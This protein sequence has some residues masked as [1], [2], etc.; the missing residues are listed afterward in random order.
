MAPSVLAVLAVSLLEVLEATKRDPSTD[1]QAFSDLP[2]LHDAECSATYLIRFRYMTRTQ[3]EHAVHV[4][5]GTSMLQL[6]GKA[7]RYMKAEG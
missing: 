4:V 6:R 5:N 7:H 2:R 3:S 1:L